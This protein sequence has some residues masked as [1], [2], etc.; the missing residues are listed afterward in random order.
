MKAMIVKIGVSGENSSA[1]DFDRTSWNLVVSGWLQIS[2]T[3]LKAEIF[4]QIEFLM[5][6]MDLCRG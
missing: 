1:L 3:F 6:A 5:A 4:F 2:S